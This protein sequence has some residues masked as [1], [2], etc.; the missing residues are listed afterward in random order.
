MTTGDKLFGIVDGTNP[1]PSLWNYNK[2]DFMGNGGCH[3]DTDMNV[4]AGTDIPAGVLLDVDLVSRK[5]YV[6]KNALVVD[7]GT[8]SAPRVNK[9]H[10]FQVGDNVFVSSSAVTI[11][12][13]DKTNTAYDVLTLSA[14][15]SGAVSG[16]YLENS[17]ESG[18]DPVMAHVPNAV[19]QEWHYNV[20][21]G[22]RVKAVVVRIY[23]DVDTTPFTVPVSPVQKAALN[24]TGRFLLY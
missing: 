18:A 2:Q 13:I 24:A 14:A 23:Q 21:T 10:F 8:T 3:F 9:N 17:K 20:Q 16:A 11:T 19:L 22:D 12:G 5:A 4:D 1:H 7:G 15:C 6:V